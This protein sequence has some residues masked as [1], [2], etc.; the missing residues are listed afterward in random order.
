[1]T[2]LLVSNDATPVASG[3]ESFADYK[4]YLDKQRTNSTMR[5][6]RAALNN[7][8]VAMAKGNK[9]ATADL[10]PWRHLRALDFELTRAELSKRYAVPTVNKSLI[11]ARGVM[12]LV[13]LRG[14]I[15]HDEYERIL[16][17][18]KTFSH[19]ATPAGRAL[20]DREYER[21]ASVTKSDATPAG[22]RDYAIITLLRAGGFRRHEVA[23]MRIEDYDSDAASITIV[24]KRD[25]RRT[26][27]IHAAIPA[28]TAWLAIRG[29]GSGHLFR[30]ISKFNNILQDGISDRAIYDIIERR[31]DASGVAGFTP[32]DLR[33]TY[34]TDA[35]RRGQ[36]LHL[37]Q[38]QAG[39]ATLAQTARYDRSE[40]DE[41]AA[42]A[43]K[44][45]LP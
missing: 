35:I 16:E 23:K 42:M 41:R 39:H 32:H 22:V 44:L 11:A 37:I 43:A 13:W 36:P 38:K 7:F 21:L 26:V 34:I 4:A 6:M 20:N 40:D 25:K 3:G 27:Y 2:E 45:I 29:N 33:R 24:G 9:D 18:S 1:M 12:R 15:S 10:V 17:A 8:A 31:R 28:L 5:T 30:R 19:D 14:V